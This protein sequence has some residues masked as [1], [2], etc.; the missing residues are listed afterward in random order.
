MTA[1]A[2]PRPAI[3]V[4]GFI[5]L[6]L[7]AGFVALGVWQVERRAWKLDLI[8]Q[9]DA[10]ATAAPVASK[11]AMRVRSAGVGAV[12]TSRHLAIASSTVQCSNQSSGSRWL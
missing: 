3:W 10:R 9:V 1:H 7:L 11:T 6:L 12:R 8:R 2:R 4:A 5:A